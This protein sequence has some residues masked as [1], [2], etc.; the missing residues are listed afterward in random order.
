MLRKQTSHKLTIM[1]PK[2]LEQKF[3]KHFNVIMFMLI[4]VVFIHYQ[5]I[6]K[7]KWKHWRNFSVGIL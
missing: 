6:C 4:F 2:E 5:K 3:Y 7:Y 1:N